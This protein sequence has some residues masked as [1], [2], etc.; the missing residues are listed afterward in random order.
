M[1]EWALIAVL[2]GCLAVLAPAADAGEEKLDVES[3]LSELGAEDRATR[4]YAQEQLASGLARLSTRD[5]QAAQALVSRMIEMLGETEAS[6]ATNLASSLARAPRPWRARGHE[7][8]K[9]LLYEMMLA[10]EQHPR[11]QLS[12]DQ[13]LMNAQGLYRDAIADYNDDRVDDIEG[14]AGKFQ[15]V[16][17]RFPRSAYAARA[18]YFLARYFTRAFFVLAEHPTAMLEAADAEYVALFERLD[19]G[20]FVITGNVELDA[21]YYGALNRAL[22]GDRDETLARLEAVAAR[23]TGKE[24]EVYVYCFF[25]EFGPGCENVVDDYF[26]GP[27][28]AA[29]RKAM[30]DAGMPNPA[31][32]ST[33]VAAVFAAL[34]EPAATAEGGDYFVIAGSVKSAEGAEALAEKFNAILREHGADI[35]A[36]VYLPYQGSEYHAVVVGTMLSLEDAQRAQAVAV[37]AGLPKDTYLWRPP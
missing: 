28:L 23:A 18:N 24:T 16:F 34:E 21:F 6:I 31:E 12:L 37:E 25:R 13:A 29:T 11:L 35:A 17:E 36:E 10:A 33:F 19:E 5:P 8:A 27:T 32:P 4:R 1:R 30:D 3:V 15:E 9:T 20:R 26:D 22:L 7:A 2:G 14:T